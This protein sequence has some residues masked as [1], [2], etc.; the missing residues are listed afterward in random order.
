[1][2]AGNNSQ[3]EHGLPGEKYEEAA[4]SLAPLS[5]F[6]LAMNQAYRYL[7][8]RGLLV[9]LFVQ[10]F[11]KAFQELSKVEAGER[12][13]VEIPFL[14]KWRGLK[15]S[16]LSP[17]WLILQIPFKL[18]FEI[19]NDQVAVSFDSR[20]W[21]RNAVNLI[22]SKSRVS[23][24][25]SFMREF[26][27]RSRRDVDLKLHSPQVI[28]FVKPALAL[29]SVLLYIPW[30]VLRTLVRSSYTT[31]WAAFRLVPALLAI[32]IVVFI[33][34]DAWKTFGLETNWRFFVL[35]V[36]ITALTTTATFV[37]LKGQGDWR[38]STGYSVEGARLLTSWVSKTPARLLLTADVNPFFPVPT[39][40]DSRVKSQNRYLKMHEINISA[41]YTFTIVGNV[42]AVAFWI[43][44][45]F[46]VVGTI[47]I[48]GS[49]TQE[50]SGIPADVVI[51][52]DLVGQ[53]FI[54]TRRV[55]LVSVVLG[56]IAALTF[57]SGT[58][59][60][61]DKR[62]IF[63]DNALADLEGALG[64][65]AYY[66]G[67]VIA[68]LLRLHDTGALEKLGPKMSQQLSKALDQIEGSPYL[69]DALSRNN[70]G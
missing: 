69:I 8:H 48:S 2:T 57:A 37:A 49:Q 61:T 9:V 36:L 3:A 26:N 50:L 51:H 68:L 4:K 53:S 56:G 44:L 16:M 23:Q 31:L 55:I 28:L 29:A 11:Y 42:I 52:F 38:T 15:W 22:P 1:M 6:E 65:L 60:D 19:K 27:E 67:T 12:V 33:T 20:R 43:A 17:S 64:A 18:Q 66:Y 70:D 13:L 39:S 35:I 34:G 5:E 45:A 41:L 32:L 21:M 62:H 54:V 47:A 46:I 25:N 30:Y 59:Q 63:T 10:P 24:F 14:V 40:N 58:L 7:V